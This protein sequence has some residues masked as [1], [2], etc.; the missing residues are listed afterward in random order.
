MIAAWANSLAALTFAGL[1]LWRLGSSARNPGHW[2]L[3]ASFALTT[4]WAWLAA[5]APGTP[6]VSFA[7]T[8]RNL[9]WIGLLHNIFDPSSGDTRQP[10]VR[11]VYAAV[12]AVLGLQLIADSILLTTTSAAVTDTGHILRVT[13]AAGALVLVHNLYGQASPGSRSSIRYA[14]IALALSWTYDLNLYTVAYL[15]SAKAGGLAD[16][17]GAVVAITGGFFALGAKHEDGWRVRLSRAATFQS[18]SLLAICAYFAVMAVVATALRGTTL[19]W[20]R[21]V[22][23]AVIAAMTVAA[24]ALLPSPRARAWAKVKVAKHVFEHR[25]DYRTEWLRFTDTLGS[26]RGEEDRPLGERVVKAFADIVECPGGLLLE[27]IRAAPLP[28]PP[29][30]AGRAR[31]LGPTT[32]KAAALSGRRLG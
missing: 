24:M 11:L 18:L 16:W 8:A 7:E 31:C 9:V 4:C 17:R 14:M 5:V 10:A 26:S 15:D 23:V 19:D 32:W 6:L 3:L 20:P 21:T 30:A 25:Y 27:M 12:A 22:A 28:L 13:A 2:L 1:L 29:T